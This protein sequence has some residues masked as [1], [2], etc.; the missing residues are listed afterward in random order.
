MWGAS[1]RD[2]W[3][4]SLQLGLLAIVVPALAV[5]GWP[6]AADRD[7]VPMLGRWAARRARHPELVRALGFVALDVG[8]VVFWRLPAVA[9]GVVHHRPLVAVEALTLVV[10]GVGLW[11]E[12]VNCPPFTPR[13]ARPWR[14]VLAALAMWGMWIDCYVVGLSA[15]SW[16]RAFPHDAGGLSVEA[17][18][19]LAVGV[20]FALALGA[21]IPVVFADVMA[22][23]GQSGDP[24][25][26][27]RRLVRGARRFGT[28]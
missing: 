8:A 1:A 26:E 20:L 23:L 7:R 27:L 10:A 19:Q 16:Y 3:A 14:A 4:A 17:D 25:D 5:T 12:L 24:D 2:E 18:Q 15:T 21:F 28:P 22:W 11:L 6:L 9:D 13:V